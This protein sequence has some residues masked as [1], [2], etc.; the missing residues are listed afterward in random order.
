MTSLETNASELM[1][2]NPTLGWLLYDG[3]CGVCRT[4]VPLWKDTLAKIG[5]DIAPLQSSWVVEAVRLSENELQT[6]ILLLFKDRQ[7]VRGPEVYRFVMKRIWWAM[8]FYLLSILP[9]IRQIFD[10][11]YRTFAR[12]RFRISSACRLN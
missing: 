8:P 9:G 10:Y 7:L 6:D 12:N 3:S 4:W 2:S 5:L 1:R 11:T